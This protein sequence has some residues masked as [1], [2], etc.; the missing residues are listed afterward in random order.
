MLFED[1]GKLKFKLQ[2]V[3][4]EKTF[5]ILEKYDNN[6]SCEDKKVSNTDFL[7]LKL[8][9]GNNAYQSQQFLL[10]SNL[11]NIPQLVKYYWFS[12]TEMF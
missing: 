5:N 11:I 3:L 9:F 1:E 7:V 2:D 4:H 8:N 6:Y 10:K 12:E